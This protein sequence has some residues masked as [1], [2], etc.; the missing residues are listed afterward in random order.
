MS[1]TQTDT[2]REGQQEQQKAPGKAA[3]KAIE[4]VAARVLCA[5]AVGNQRFAAGVVVEGIPAEVAQAHAAML[6]SN[7]AAVSRA[8]DRGAEVLTYGEA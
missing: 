4:V 5:G 2:T 1:E 6:D 7:P 3:K 8:K